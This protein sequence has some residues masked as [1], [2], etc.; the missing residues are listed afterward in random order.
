MT[1]PTNLSS[2]EEQKQEYKEEKNTRSFINDPKGEQDEE[3]QDVEKEQVEE[4][5]KVFGNEASLRFG[6][7]IF[8]K[9]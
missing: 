8:Q 1:S 3:D 5:Q 9:M 7:T 2:Q 6:C 4:K